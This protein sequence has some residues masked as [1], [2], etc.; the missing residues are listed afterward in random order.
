MPLPHTIETRVA[1]ASEAG[2]RLDVFL[3]A[4]LGQFSRSQWKARVT[5]IAVNGTPARLSRIMR[6]GDVVSLTYADPPPMDLLPEAIPLHV[7]F[8]N[9]DVIVI[10]KAQGMVVHPGSGNRT[11]TLVNALL[12]RCAGL[13]EGFGPENLRPGIVHRLDKETS[14]VMIVAKN[15]RAHEALSSQFRD[16]S[17]RKRYLAVVVGAPPAGEGLIDA[18]LARDPRNRQRFT[19]A[20]SGGRPALTRYKVQ[21]ILR[22]GGARY[23]VVLL[24]P[25]TGRTHQLRVHLRHIGTPIL[26]D[27]VY[28]QK[29]ALCPD[30]TLMLH[31]RSLTIRLPGESA[32]RTFS[33]PP[34]ARFLQTVRRIQSFSP[35]KGL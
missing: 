27:P 32:A 17:V 26:G 12:F 10:D 34:P 25:R 20:P 31:S 5:G 15:A 28:G 9:A 22:A 29:D 35:S 21:R 33:A 1:E 2:V 30:A 4:K 16:R 13:A 8:E 11:G 19:C 3:A 6:V 7:I 18:R 14:G 24:A 23:A